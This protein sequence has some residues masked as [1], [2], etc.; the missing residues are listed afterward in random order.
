MKTRLETI[1]DVLLLRIEGHVSASAT[2]PFCDLLVASARSGRNMLIV[3]LAEG[4]QLGRSG[5]RGLVVAAKLM[6]VVGRKFAIVAS[7]ELC[8]WLHRVSFVHLL[9]VHHSKADA[10]AAMAGISEHATTTGPRAVNR[11]DPPV[12]RMLPRVA[13]E[14]S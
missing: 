13:S 5:V 8:D 6:Q 9:P 2:G 14:P 1:G 11:P 7:P 10:L 3:E 12:R 4:F